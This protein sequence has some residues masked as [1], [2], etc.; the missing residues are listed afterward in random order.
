MANLRANKIVG[1]GSTDAG[2]VFQGDIK[3]NS[4]G[5][6][7]FPK[8]DTEQRGRGLGLYAGGATP[9]ATAQIAS[10]QIQSMGTASDWGDLTVA[11][12]APGSGA[13]TTRGVWAGG[14]TPTR[15]NTIDYVTI[16]TSGTAQDFGDC[17]T[18]K[19]FPAGASNNTRLV[20][21]GGNTTS[22]ALTNTIDL[23]I[24][25]TTGNATDFGDMATATAGLGEGASPT[26][27][28]F[29]GGW[30]DEPGYT[31]VNTMEYITFATTG[32]TSD[33]GDMT[34]AR[35]GV[36]GGSSPT[37]MI[38]MAGYGSASPGWTE[39][40]TIDY[41]TIA[42]TGNAT[43]FGDTPVVLADIGDM[44]SNSIRCVGAGGYDGPAAT[45]HINYVTIATTG[46]GADFG[47]CVQA[48]FNASGLSDS[49]GGI[50]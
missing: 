43:D 33:F 46:N 28:V 23:T 42:S 22:P 5:V 32:N 2:V 13:S 40:N 4:Q 10:I 36:A 11:R 3:I 8:G 7:Y 18:L 9:S 30:T 44:M 47:D 38:M 37:R 29:A 17:Q 45:N 48:V 27:G 24:I 49:H 12:F 35:K 1:I 25:A 16:Q 41:V 50:E 21:A 20:N 15:L 14:A 31:T 34:V 26:R 19:Y 6:M 39:L